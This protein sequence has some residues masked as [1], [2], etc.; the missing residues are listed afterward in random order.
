MLTTS[1][2]CRGPR[3]ALGCVAL[4]LANLAQARPERFTDG[5]AALLEPSLAPALQARE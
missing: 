1:R 3:I 4:S 2:I 5:L